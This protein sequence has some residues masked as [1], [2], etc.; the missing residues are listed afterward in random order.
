VRRIGAEERRA[1]LAARHRLAASAR[2]EGLAE[3]AREMVGLHG[4][5]PASVFLAAAA[6]THGPGAGAFEHALYETRTVVRMLG[7]RRTMFVVPVELAPVVHAGVTRGLVP[8]ERRRLAQFL[9]QAGVAG[10]G[11]GD[12]WLR[13]VGEAT[14]EALEARGEATAAELTA[15][16]PELGGQIPFG[17][18]KRWAGVQGVSTRVLFL[19]GAEGRIVR[20]RPR[21]SWVSSQYRWAPMESW[22]PGGIPE[23][24]TE[25]A[26]AELVRRWLAT[27]GPGTA[28]DLRWWT[29][30]TAAEVKRALASVGPTEV[31][32]GGATGLA[33]GDDLDPPP[34]PE[35]WAALLPALDPTVMGWTER[36]WYLGGHGPALFDR[37]G[38]AGPTVWWDGR[39]V[40]GW[41]QRKDGEVAYRFLEDPGADAV[42]AVQQAADEL[43]AWLGPVRVT[44]RF[45]TPLER[46][47]SA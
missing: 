23:L 15:G 12:R 32:L 44:P 16:V 13:R 42:A 6:R 31:D 25:S 4:T 47:L 29:G 24:S 21:G 3:A 40:G 30:W 34:S 38:N 11:D 14:V 27:F 35:P 45:R 17:A 8:G 18:G 20:A 26:Q 9:E 41:A 28:A 39:V 7:M 1:R 10:E 19:L 5:D 36:G 33:L 37:S 46:E 22:I 43:R 2:V